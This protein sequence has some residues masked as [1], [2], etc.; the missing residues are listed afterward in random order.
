M[1]FKLE[2]VCEVKTQNVSVLVT[3]ATTDQNVS[4]LVTIA[5]TDSL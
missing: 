4:V 1:K 3:I 2:T 5:T